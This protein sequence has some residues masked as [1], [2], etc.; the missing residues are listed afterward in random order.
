MFMCNRSPSQQP[1]PIVPTVNISHPST[2]TTT[3]THKQRRMCRQN[4]GQNTS[5]NLWEWRK[6]RKRGY[7]C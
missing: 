2:V 6:D 3:W 5:D 7:S 1:A 4:E